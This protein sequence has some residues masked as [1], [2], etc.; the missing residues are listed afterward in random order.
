MSGEPYRFVGLKQLT[1]GHND[2]LSKRTNLFAALV[3]VV[4]YP[5]DSGQM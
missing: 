5:L 2:V 1:S 4:H 3:S